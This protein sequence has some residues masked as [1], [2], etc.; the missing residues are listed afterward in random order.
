MRTEEEGKRKM[1]FGS[2]VGDGSDLEL[3]SKHLVLGLSF[4]SP[5]S[6][7]VGVERWDGWMEC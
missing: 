1:G 3:D 2:R 6:V 7:E 5:L 4:G